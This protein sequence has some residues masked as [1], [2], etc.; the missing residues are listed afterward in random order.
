MYDNKPQLYGRRKGQKLG[1]QQNHL[2][3]SFLP[4]L[5]IDIDLQAPEKTLELESMFS[6]E[7]SEYWLEIGFGDGEHFIWQA[8]ANPDVGFIGCEPF[9]N[10]MGKCLVSVHENAIKNIRL[11]DN[12]ARFL[13]D[14]LPEC[15]LN[16][17]FILFPDPWPKRRHHKRRFITKDNLDR[18]ARVMKSGAQLRIASD[19]DSYITSILLALQHHKDFTWRDETAEDWRIRKKDWPETRYERKALR[20]GRKPAYLTFMRT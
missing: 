1:K 19:I 12:D 5:H 3:E 13:L 20:E 2:L 14:R 8:N 11:Y 16:R 7:I 10:G 4:E 17:V 15:S 6:N 18:L 9:L